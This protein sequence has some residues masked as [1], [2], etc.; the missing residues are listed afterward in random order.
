MSWIEDEAARQ[1]IFNARLAET[2]EALKSALTRDIQDYQTHFG[3][4]ALEIKE[5]G[6]NSF[7][8]MF[9][10]GTDRFTG[11]R[12]IH[13]QID[14]DKRELVAAVSPS[15]KSTTFRIIPGPDGT[16][17]FERSGKQYTVDEVSREILKPH[18]SKV[19]K[20]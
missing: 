2:W 20:A 18:L 6:D 8:I 10:E 19:E 1:A 4:S 5:T 12:D 16:P 13:V 7:W 17:L 3:L 15:R 11:R 14:F 9:Q